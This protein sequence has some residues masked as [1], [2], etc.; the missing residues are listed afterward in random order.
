MS[1]V[2]S[3]EREEFC[4][5]LVVIRFVF[6]LQF[7]IFMRVENAITVFILCGDIVIRQF[8]YVASKNEMQFTLW[9]QEKYRGHSHFF[10]TVFFSYVSLTAHSGRVGFMCR[11]YFDW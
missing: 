7:P 3:V 4:P 2:F 1:Y 10:I 6:Y 11:V 8:H 9:V 5:D